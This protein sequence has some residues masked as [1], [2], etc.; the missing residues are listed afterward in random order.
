MAASDDRNQIAAIHATAHLALNGVGLESI[1]QGILRCAMDYGKYELGVVRFLSADSQSLEL[2]AHAGFRDEANAASMQRTKTMEGESGRTNFRAIEAA[3]TQV[4]PDLAT[5][6]RMRVLTREGARTVVVVPIRAGEE[7]LGV[8]TLA[9]RRLHE[10]SSEELVVLETMANHL[11]IV[12][13]KT[14][15]QEQ[16]SHQALYD[17]LTG[18]ANRTLLNELLNQALRES[19]RSRTCIAALF[20]DLD[21][22]K[23]INDSLGHAAGDRVLVE[24]SRRLSAVIRAGDTV[25]RLGGDEF[26]F[27][28][29]SPCDLASASEVARRVIEALRTPLDVSGHVVQVNASVGVAV[30]V[31]GDTGES[32][33]H[34]A[35]LAMFDA[36][37]TGGA[38]TSVFRSSLRAAASQ[39]SEFERR[40]AAAVVE[41]AMH[42][43]YQPIVDVRSHECVGL[44]AVVRW[45]DPVEG[46]VPPSRFIPVLEASGLINHLGR[47][48]LREA[49]R[50][51]VEWQ[52]LHTLPHLSISVNVSAVQLKQPDF[53]STVQEAL[54][55]S[56]LSPG[57]LILEITESMLV[58]ETRV[59]VKRLTQLR[60]LGVRI[61]VDDFG[62]G[63][64]SLGNLRMFPLDILKID[65]TFI[66]G[67]PGDAGKSALLAAIVELGTALRLAVI[68]EGVEDS[69]QAGWLVSTSCQLA[70]GFHYAKA[71]S[72]SDV[73][74]FLVAEAA[75]E[76]GGTQ[77]RRETV[78]A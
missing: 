47:S 52:Q 48:V 25:S 13:Q 24:V 50:N 54:D 35:D 53:V 65:R 28:L 37:G 40:L 3:E 44:E 46:V 7:S 10:P 61:A 59:M 8:V 27:L 62:T 21:D 17:G 23:S 70:Q 26:A 15:L 38:R 60:R 41:E 22:F 6:P 49:C 32:L 58:S 64:S 68:A 78:R 30:S 55:D 77:R 42:V 33:L 18:V 57:S 73:A 51:A 43:C 19:E 75:G 5:M 20:I 76:P 45:T 16:L 11:G 1:S 34:S 29:R 4:L 63:F 14:R 39:R 56:G 69:A 36:K 2:V 9:M 72:S 71:L 66:E 12:L 67:V 74:A 31:P